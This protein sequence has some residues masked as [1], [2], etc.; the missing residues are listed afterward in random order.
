MSRRSLDGLDHLCDDAFNR[1]HGASTVR[2]ADANQPTPHV[3]ALAF[4]TDSGSSAMASPQE[5]P[6][7]DRLHY[8]VLPDVCQKKRHRWVH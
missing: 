7:R 8:G 1:D 4:V 2:V 3:I 6:I 5:I